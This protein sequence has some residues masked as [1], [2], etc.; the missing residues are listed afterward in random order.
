MINDYYVKQEMKEHNNQI[1][2]QKRINNYNQAPMNV[3]KFEE[4]SL[5]GNGPIQRNS[6]NL[7]QI[8]NDQQNI[9]RN[10]NRNYVE[11]LP[12][13]NQPYNANDY[14]N[15][16][17]KHQVELAE[18]QMKEEYEK[19]KQTAKKY[20]EDLDNIIYEKRNKNFNQRDS[21]KLI[22]PTNLN[23]ELMPPQGIA[24][25]NL[26]EKNISLQEQNIDERYINNPKIPSRESQKNYVEE[27]DQIKEK[28]MKKLDVS[29]EIKQIEEANNNMRNEQEK[30]INEYE[31]KLRAQANQDF[32]KAD[33]NRFAYRKKLEGAQKKQ[34]YIYF[35]HLK[36]M[37]PDVARTL[38]IDN[39][40]KLGNY[41]RREPNQNDHLPNPNNDQYPEYP[42]RTQIENS[43][44]HTPNK[45]IETKTIDPRS[46]NSINL[47]NNAVRKEENYSPDLELRVNPNDYNDINYDQY[48]RGQSGQ[49]R[50]LKKESILK[51]AGLQAMKKN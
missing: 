8:N 32:L 20:K 41:I 15:M 10:E 49:S 7:D 26:N 37:Y 34:D 28:Q 9:P 36:K 38:S 6:S 21:G 25:E 39:N 51:E 40:S 18:R 11:K 43:Q 30:S 45:L 24:Q 1:I 3:N 22:E 12:N 33:L 14:W 50:S 16:I 47:Q 29:T 2:P 42:Q 44:L 5:L 13:K 17:T 27:T 23:T 4:G 46:Y 35:Q 19:R 48:L 31:K